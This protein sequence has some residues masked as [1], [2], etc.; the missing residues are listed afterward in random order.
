MYM[1]KLLST[2]FCILFSASL[3]A[4]DSL[5]EAALVKNARD[6]AVQSYY[7]FTGHRARLYNGTEHTGYLNSIIG[8]AYHITDS[9]SIGQIY[10]DGLAF[11]PVQMRYDILKD[12]LVIKHYSGLQISLLSEK[13]QEFTFRNRHF[14]RHVYDSIARIGVPTG[15][16]EHMFEGRKITVLARRS[17]KLEE[18]VTDAVIR[19]FIEDDHYYLLKEGKYNYFKSKTSF[20]KAFGPDGRQVRKHLRKAKINYRKQRDAAILESAKFYEQLN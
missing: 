18:K 16:Y 14:V 19:E 8:N 5:A 12:E 13:V 1:P 6:F 2:L 3:C 15:I 17:K 7:Q 10:Y 11:F 4:Q 9:L 20:L